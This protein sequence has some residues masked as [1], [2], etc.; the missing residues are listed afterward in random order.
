[1]H[2]LVIRHGLHLL[3]GVDFERQD[4]VQSILHNSKQK[5]NLFKL[6]P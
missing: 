5:D 2:V 6:K 1:M 3:P 4:Q